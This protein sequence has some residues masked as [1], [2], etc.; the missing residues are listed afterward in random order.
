MT[1]MYDCELEDFDAWCGGQA[2]VEEAKKEGKF[3]ALKALVSEYFN[4]DNPVSETTLNDFLWFDA[5]DMLGLWEAE[6]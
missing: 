5:P 2:T 3:D 4:D 1:L 6:S